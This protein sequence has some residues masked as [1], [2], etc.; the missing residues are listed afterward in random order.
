[1]IDPMTNKI[2]VDAK[3]GIRARASKVAEKLLGLNLTDG[4]IHMTP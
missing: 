3:L 1:V 4:R 2:I